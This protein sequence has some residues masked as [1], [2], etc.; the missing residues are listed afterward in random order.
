[1]LQSGWESWI[2]QMNNFCESSL[3]I[4]YTYK[5]ESEKTNGSSEGVDSRGRGWFFNSI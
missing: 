3:R 1:M 4:S 5:H 2:I